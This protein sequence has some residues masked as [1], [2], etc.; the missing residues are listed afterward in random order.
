LHNTFNLDKEIRQ[1]NK[2]E[3]KET[4]FY[5]ILFVIGIVG[6]TLL[7]QPVNATSG[8]GNNGNHYG[9]N[10][11]GDVN[12]I[13]REI[14]TGYIKNF[15]GTVRDRGTKLLFLNYK[16]YNNWKNNFNNPTNNGHEQEFDYTRYCE[17]NEDYLNFRR[18][19]SGWFD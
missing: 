10:G 12:N 17:I 7:L 13:H 11:N 9:N 4:I 1:H 15:D 16:Y 8:N 2:E 14:P 5:V 18:L 6:L 19:P 3:T